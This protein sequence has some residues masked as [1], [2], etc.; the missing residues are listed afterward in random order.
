MRVCA[1]VVCVLL[2]V[3]CSAAM[4]LE[5]TTI[6]EFAGGVND[7]AHPYGNLILDGSTLYG[8]TTV[9]GDYDSGTIFSINTDG[10]GFTIKHEFA[11]GPGDGSWPYG[12][13]TQSGSLPLYGMTY[14]GGAANNG[15]IFVVTPEPGTVALVGLGLGTVAVLRRRRTA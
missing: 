15:V 8:M 6:H 2:L 4:A 1:V 5:V 7:G 14:Y 9:G 12:D 13:L 3:L 10:S 11:G